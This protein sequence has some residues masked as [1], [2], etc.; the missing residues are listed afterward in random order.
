MTKLKPGQRFASAAFAVLLALV[1]PVTASAA[2]KVRFAYLKTVSL[3]PFFYAT[4]QGYFTAEGID[5]DLIAVPGGPAVGAAI[6]SGSAD[7]GY[8]APPPV[9]IAR[10]Q[11]QPFRF[12]MALEY[13]KTPERLWGYIVAS[14]KSGIQTLKEAVGKSVALGPP[15]GL[16]ELGMRDWL[17]KAGVAYKDI[18]PLNNPFPQMPAM[19]EIGTADIA[20][21]ADPF[22]SAAL[23]AKSPA[24]LLDRGYLA[25]YP[26]TYRIEGLFANE[27]WIT[28][29]P[30]EIA[31]IKKGFIRAASELKSNVPLVKK[32]LVDEYK[33]PPSLIDDKMLD[34]ILEIEPVASEFQPLADK[35]YSYGMLSKPL[36][37]EDIIATAK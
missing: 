20:C 21:I 30:K 27:T 2:E 29:H 15:G 6:A 26:Q 31:G 14:K 19:L 17:A 10:E 8:A 24:K 22:A 9:M 35:M 25:A 16:C 11:G 33:L 12:F 18:K 28:A 37:A 3:L 7:I 23:N 4:Q 1:G 13:E 5:M 34:R 36:K 32:L